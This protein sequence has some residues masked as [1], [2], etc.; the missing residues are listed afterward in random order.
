MGGA[1]ATLNPIELAAEIVAAFVSNNSLPRAELAAVIETVHAAVKRLA[2]GAEVAPA[3]IDAPAP[4]VSIRKSVTPDYLICLE[5]GKRFKSLRRHLAKLGMTPEQYRAKWDLPSTYPMV[6]PNY[7]A[8]RSALARAIGLGQMR[9]SYVVAPAVS[10]GTIEVVAP[11]PASIDVN[12]VVVASP[13]SVGTSE[14]AAP[15]PPPD[16]KSEGLV[17]PPEVPVKRKPGR[18]RKATA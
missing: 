11:T 16:A 2:E 12:N 17:P 1:V 13:A 14:A 3:V 7:A 5:D 4:A 18:P 8:Q 15:Q 6:A 9:E 10:A